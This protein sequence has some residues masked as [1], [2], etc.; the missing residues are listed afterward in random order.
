[1]STNFYKVLD[2]GPTAD[3][4]EIKKAYRKL[5]MKYHPDQNKDSKEAEAKFKEINE[6]YDTLKDP[7]KKAA[8]DQYGHDSYTQ[9]GSGGGAGA[10]AAGF[11]NFSDIFEDM[12]GGMGGGGRS[13]AGPMRGA[14]MQF[15]MDISLEDAY[16]GK[17]AKIR[18]PSIE[19]CNTCKGSGSKDSGGAE[20]CSSCNGNGRVRAQQGFFTIERTCPTCNGEGQIIKDPCSPCG[21]AGRV[22]KEKTLKVNIPTG[23]DQ[24]RRIRLAG[25]GEAGFKGGPPGDLYV[26]IGVKSHKFF[27]RDGA[28]LHC[29]IPIPMTTA[30]IGS[31]IEVPT[32]DGKKSK[33]KI[34]EGTQTG[35]QFRLKGKGMT[36]LK[37]ST[38]GDMFIE[39]YVE[40][41]VN[42]DKK[43]KKIIQDL[44]DTLQKAGKHSP[45][46]DGF[47]TKM[48]DIWSDLKD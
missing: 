29:R 26:L 24:G 46:S 48:K 1:M 44:G 19:K 39:I 23:I 12:F 33:V 28:N 42:L 14:D 47:F 37:S 20:K 25:E 18:V 8:Y 7:Q 17:E 3:K 34:P 9:Q 4:A 36:V 21:G 35:Q 30:V 43:Q 6:A 40:T 13:T 15:Q 11:G 10:G 16:N 5:A 31:S 27:K 32:I 22:K 38:H 41:P 45:E 2:V